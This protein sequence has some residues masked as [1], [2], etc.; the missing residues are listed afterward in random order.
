M[1]CAHLLRHAYPIRSAP[2]NA[3]DEEAKFRPVQC[4]QATSQSSKAIRD[5][6][7][8]N[9]PGCPPYTESKQLDG[10]QHRPTDAHPFEDWRDPLRNKTN[11]R[12]KF[13]S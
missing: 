5:L 4:L 1:P 9:F 11:I 2:N 12:R 6:Q 7:Q 3:F 8:R 13:K 10:G